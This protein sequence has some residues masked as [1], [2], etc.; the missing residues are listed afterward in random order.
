[1]AAPKCT[2]RTRCMHLE[3]RLLSPGSLATPG[4]PSA[5]GY[6]WPVKGYKVRFADVVRSFFFSLFTYQLFLFHFLFSSTLVPPFVLSLRLRAR[7]RRRS[8]SVAPYIAR[9]SFFPRALAPPFVF[10]LLPSPCRRCSIRC[11]LSVVP[12]PYSL[13]IILIRRSNI[14]RL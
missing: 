2:K 7:R 5:P 4:A 8:I 1:M 6:T 13:Y 14:L 12:F 3:H 9:T 11:P 10:S